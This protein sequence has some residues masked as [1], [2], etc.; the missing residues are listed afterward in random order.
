MAHNVQV[1]NHPVVQTK[2]SQLRNTQTTPKDFREL[3]HE[4]SLLLGYE[5]SRSLQCRQYTAQT[6]VAAF[7]AFAIHPRIGLAPIMRAGIGMT[8]ALLALH[9]DAHVYHLG[10]FREKISLQPVEYYNKLPER[11]TVDLVFLLDPMIA[12]AGTACAA[13]HMLVDW[14]IPVQNIKL[15][16]IVASQTGVDVLNKEFPGLE[17]WTAA[18]DPQLVVHAGE[19]GKIAPGLGDAGDRLFNTH[20]PTFA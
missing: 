8:D 5:A 10:L 6:P 17:I 15:I 14:G 1:V 20:A 9:P 19:G 4:V 3:T 16:S 7:N 18:L 2:L 12:T 13:M 11:P